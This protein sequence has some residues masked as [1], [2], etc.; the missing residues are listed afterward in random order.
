MTAGVTGWN[1]SGSDMVSEL[2]YPPNTPFAGIR[3]YI[4]KLI[5]LKAI[6]RHILLHRSNMNRD[7]PEHQPPHSNHVDP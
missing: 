4:Q 7:E 3:V 1:M 5:G 6:C 2:S